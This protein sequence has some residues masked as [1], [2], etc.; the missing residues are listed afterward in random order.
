MTAGTSYQIGVLGLG[1][2]GAAFAELTRAHGLSTLTFDPKH[3]EASSGGFDDVARGADVLVVAVPIEALDATLH[4]CAPLLRPEQMLIDVCSVKVEPEARLR[5]IIGGRARWIASHPLFGPVSLSRGEPRTVVLCPRT[6]APDITADAAAFYR[7]IGCELALVS[8]EA[9]D[10]VMARTHVLAF[11]VA[12]ALQD[13]GAA[14]APFAP[15]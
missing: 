13:I 1:R 15:P 12:R 10:R 9:H 5:E 11:F 8:A 3:P 14:S 4:A 6:D 7:G 2:F